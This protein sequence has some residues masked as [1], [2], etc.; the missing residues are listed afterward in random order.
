[1][2]DTSFTVARAD[3]RAM[4]TA[5]VHRYAH[6]ARDNMDFAD[7]L[8]LFTEDANLVL[9]NGVEVPASK[10]A[11]VLQGEEAAYIRHHITTVDIRFTG[12]KTAS[13]DTFFFAITNEAVP[14]HWGQ[15][16]DQLVKG[17]DGTWCLQ[18]RRIIVDGAAPSGW[19]YRMYLAGG[20]EHHEEVPAAGTQR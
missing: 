8:P 10:L 3:D 2:P 15:W 1:M 7:M 18:E 17:T 16:A 13:A 6:T 5:L 12:E 4:I 19:F 14:D 9:P 20:H 11:D